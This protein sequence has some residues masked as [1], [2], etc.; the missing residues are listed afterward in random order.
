M[1]DWGHAKIHTSKNGQRKRRWKIKQ[2][3]YF[4]E[5]IVAQRP[6]PDP[7][8]VVSNKIRTFDTGATRD[9]DE[10]KL[11]F[12]G[13]LSPLAL[14]RFAEYMNKHRQQSDG[15]LRDSDNWQKGIPVKQYMKSMWRHFFAV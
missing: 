10:G 6:K 9:T 2:E 5:E 1:E 7:P 15:S 12:E 8:T 4:K 14:E 11:D 3:N 13:F